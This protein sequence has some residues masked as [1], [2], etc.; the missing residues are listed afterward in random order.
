MNFTSYAKNVKININENEQGISHILF[1]VILAVII[2]AVSLV[3]LKVYQGTKKTRNNQQVNNVQKV[4]D[5]SY[6]QLQGK[7]NTV[8][9]VSYYN[10]GMNDKVITSN[11]INLNQISSITK[12]RS[13]AG[14]DFSGLDF[15]GQAEYDRSMKSYFN[16]LPQYQGTNSVAFDAPFTGKVLLDNTTWDYPRGHQMILVP[17]ANPHMAFTIFH[18]LP[19]NGITTGSTFTAGQQIGYEDLPGQSNFDMALSMLSPQPGDQPSAEIWDS[20]FNHMTPSVLAQYQAVGV[21]LSNI[22]ISKT[23]RDANACD[24]PPN[25]QSGGPHENDPFNQ[26]ILNH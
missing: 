22:I 21:N 8:M 17:N 16:V 1:L 19:N 4:S 23:Y 2:M 20:V 10:D 9:T 5:I 25:N 11:P 18:I 26:V 6:G 14:H 24:Y 15:Q 12:F 7:N 3:G 13:C